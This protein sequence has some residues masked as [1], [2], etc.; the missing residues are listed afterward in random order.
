MRSFS[1]AMLTAMDEDVVRPIYLIQL[2]FDTDTLRLNTSA[3]DVSWNSQTW[4]GNGILKDFP[5]IYDDDDLTIEGLTVRLAGVT[6]SM[7]ALVLGQTLNQKSGVL[8]FGLLDAN[9][10]LIADPIQIFQGWLDVPKI[11]ETFEDTVIELDYESELIDFDVPR[12]HRYTHDN[13]KAFYPSDL[14]FEYVASLQDKSI[15]WGRP[16]SEKVKKGKKK[17]KKKDRGGRD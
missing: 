7:V 10:A 14:G 9:F 12:E 1:S 15:V 6:E 13:Q 17:K 2:E 16:K 5:T 3:R 8:Y 4:L 11:V